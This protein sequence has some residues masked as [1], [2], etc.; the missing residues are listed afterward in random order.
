M[1]ESARAIL[2][3]HLWRSNRRKNIGKRRFFIESNGRDEWDEVRNGRM[4]DT[5]SPM[6]CSKNGS[7]KFEVHRLGRGV[8]GIGGQDNISNLALH[9]NQISVVRR[10]Q[11]LLSTGYT[12]TC[13]S[14]NNAPLGIMYHTL[15]TQCSRLLSKEPPPD[16]CYNEQSQPSKRA[17]LRMVSHK[18]SQ[19][20]DE[21]ADLPA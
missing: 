11:R 2:R 16:K 13:R 10:R 4:N 7:S 12:F 8:R 6:S 15:P 20:S 3:R 21:C 1:L 5:D 19:R 14:K 17:I 18:F 9:Y